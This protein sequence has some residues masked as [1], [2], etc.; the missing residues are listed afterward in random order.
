[1]ELDQ[2]QNIWKSY[3]E[4]IED[5]LE[6]NK[7][8]LK[9]ASVR[10]VQSY[11][12]EFRL[13]NYIELFVDGFAVFY[14]F[15]F[16]LRNVEAFQFFIPALILMLFFMADMAWN[17]Y[18]MVV[19]DRLSYKNSLIHN[20]KTVQRLK[21]LNRLEINSLL[22]LIPLFSLA[23]IILLP[24]IFAD[25]NIFPL[26]GQWTVNYMIGSTVVAGIIVLM[27][28]LFPDKKMEEALGFLKEIS[29][30]ESEENA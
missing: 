16:L 10:K 22:V 8:L 9:E 1:M 27:L 12:Y 2:L 20:L 17:I 5:R 21:W 4:K 18:K 30:Y 26:M 25:V 14:L 3:D 23:F 29:Q 28:R 7:D 19:S 13:E 6:I 11:L 15:K 24:K